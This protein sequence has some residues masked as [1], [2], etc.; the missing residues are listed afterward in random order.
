VEGKKILVGPPER[1]GERGSLRVGPLPDSVQSKLNTKVN[2]QLSEAS[3]SEV[4]TNLQHATG[5][6]FDGKNVS[7]Q[8]PASSVSLSI[9]SRLELILDLLCYQVGMR[10]KAEAGEICFVP[11]SSKDEKNPEWWTGA[12]R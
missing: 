8:V 7:S 4:T 6:Q 12:H 2:L 3:L 9:E 11:L 1:I 5:L 10:W